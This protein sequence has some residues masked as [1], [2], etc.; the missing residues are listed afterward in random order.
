MLLKLNREIYRKDL[1]TAEDRKRNYGSELFAALK[2]Y[3]SP[4]FA[5]FF[6]NAKGYRKV[7]EIPSIP[8]GRLIV[9]SA[10]ID[11]GDFYE[12]SAELQ[13][14]H[15]S[16]KN[17]LSIFIGQIERCGLQKV[18]KELEHFYLDTI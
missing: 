12:A 10:S 18:P 16:S 7:A 11:G 1:K 13:Y 17:D 14:A 15:E 2:E 3:I 4:S 6:P 5:E 9:R 8:G